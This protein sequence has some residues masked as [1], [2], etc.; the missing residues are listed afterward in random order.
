[1]VT[2]LHSALVAGCNP[3]FG[4]ANFVLRAQL[5][6]PPLRGG[7]RWSQIALLA[8]PKGNMEQQLKAL[9]TQHRSDRKSR[10][11]RPKGRDKS[12]RADHDGDY[13]SR[14]PAPHPWRNPARDAT[15]A[16]AP[17]AR[18]W[19]KAQAR[20]QGID[21]GCFARLGATCLAPSQGG[22]VS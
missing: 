12:W 16:T 9:L 18:R 22:S 19:A 13:A 10:W 4:N 20:M 8:S 15:P 5:L 1:M 21:A 11:Q 17:A 7:G 14:A 3:A 2:V 6:V